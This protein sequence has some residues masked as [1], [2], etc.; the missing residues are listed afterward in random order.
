MLKPLLTAYRLPLTTYHY[1]LPLTAYRLPLT[2]HYSLLTKGNEHRED[3][4]GV[5]Q[6]AECGGR[7]GR[8][9]RA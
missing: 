2:P 5:E 7:R 3:A 4:E 8:E 1:R 9:H 6:E